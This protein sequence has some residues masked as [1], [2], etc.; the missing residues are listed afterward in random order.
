MIVGKAITWRDVIDSP[1]N[2]YLQPTVSND[3]STKNVTFSFQLLN[4]QFLSIQNT[5]LKRVATVKTSSIID[6]RLRLEIGYEFS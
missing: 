3:V 5:P 2:S 1:I 4:R 6:K